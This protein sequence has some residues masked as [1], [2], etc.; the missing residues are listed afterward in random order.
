VTVGFY[1][2]FLKGQ[3]MPRGFPRFPSSYRRLAGGLV[4]VLL[5]A[6]ASL[7]LLA[8]EI[9]AYRALPERDPVTIHEARIARLR[10]HL[11]ATGAVGYVTTVANE[12]IFA[13]EQRFGNVEYI[14]QYALTQYTLAPLIVHNNPE[15]PLVVGNF[16]DGPPP[17][18][19]LERHGLSQ[20]RDLGDGVVLFRREARP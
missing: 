19:F 2:F 12:R 4:V 15:M 16:L 17:P 1:S 20:V 13:D 11:P 7:G 18:G 14:A 8:Q 10:P 5:T 6:W 3:P 9:A